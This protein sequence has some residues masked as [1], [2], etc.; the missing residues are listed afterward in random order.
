MFDYRLGDIFGCV[1]DIGWIIGYS[2]VVY[3]FFCN[4]A[5]SVF[6]ESISV[7]FDVG[8]DWGFK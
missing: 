6:F 5:I 7:Y 3:G 8:E 4:G 1:V 2:Y